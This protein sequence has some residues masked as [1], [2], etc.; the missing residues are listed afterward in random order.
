MMMEL[1]YFYEVLMNIVFWI[2]ECVLIFLVASSQQ[3]SG[4]KL[5]PKKVMMMMVLLCAN[6]NVLRPA[7]TYYSLYDIF[8]F[9]GR[10]GLKTEAGGNVFKNQF[11]LNKV[12]QVLPWRYLPYLDNRRDT[13]EPEKLLAA[14]VE[15]MVANPNYSDNTLNLSPVEIQLEWID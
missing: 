10:R 2:K 4:L 8:L 13:V 12:T 6:K 7:L 3:S 1:I 14:A 11:T 5:D 9:Y 15:L